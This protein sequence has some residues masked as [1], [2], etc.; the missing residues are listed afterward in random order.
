MDEAQTPVLD[1]PRHP[2]QTHPDTTK[3]MQRAFLHAVE[4]V[5][6]YGQACRLLGIHRSTVMQWAKRNP[7]MRERMRLNK[8]FAEEFIGDEIIGHLHQRALAHPKDDPMS[9]QI[10][11]YITKK[12]FPSYR[13]N[14]VTNINVVG[15]AAIQFNLNQSVSQADDASTDEA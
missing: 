4:Q 14:A 8:E 15:P 11:M 1:P 13:E 7:A 10:A 5:G 2:N 9:A 3:A 6:T 12:I